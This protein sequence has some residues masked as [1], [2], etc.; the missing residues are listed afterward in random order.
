[1]RVARCGIEFFNDLCRDVAEFG[2]G[3]SQF[4]S[5]GGAVE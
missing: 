3:F 4:D 5:A 1:M 2:T